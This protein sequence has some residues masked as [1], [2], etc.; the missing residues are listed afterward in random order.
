M[1][2]D[3]DDP[4]SRSP[5][6]SLRRAALSMMAELAG[7]LSEIDCRISDST[8]LLLVNDRTDVTASM[9]SRML[10]IQR[11]NMVPLV[12]RLESA[13]LVRKMP[14]D[15]KSFAIVLTP[16]GKKRRKQA[17]EIIGRFED[18]LMG[19]IPPEHRDHFKPALDSLWRSDAP[20]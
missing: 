9:I 7:R 12:N 1:S 20:S 11:T 5:G 14:L 3:E 15:G 4:I 18:D 6:H 10:D 19:K 8:V 17:L 13:G 16:E 2:D